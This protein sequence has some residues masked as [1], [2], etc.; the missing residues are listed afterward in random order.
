MRGY[1]ELADFEPLE[2]EPSIDDLYDDQG[3]PIA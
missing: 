3:N 2:D 1:F